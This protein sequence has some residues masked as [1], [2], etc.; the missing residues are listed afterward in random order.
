VLK[1]TDAAVKKEEP[2]PTSTITTLHAQGAEPVKT[3]EQELKPVVNFMIDD[4]AATS[5]QVAVQKDAQPTNKVSEHMAAQDD[6]VVEPARKVSMDDFSFKVTD[7]DSP[8]TDLLKKQDDV[9][10]FFVQL[11]TQIEILWKERAVMV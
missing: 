7:A 6:A 10:E 8:V 4:K 5:P 11:Q 1:S 2:A 9:Y 3:R